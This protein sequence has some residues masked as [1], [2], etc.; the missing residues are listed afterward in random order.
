[1]K[2]IS[3]LW[4]IT[5]LI[6]FILGFSLFLAGIVLIGNY[7]S[8]KEE[9]LK[10]RSFVTA[11]TIAELPEVKEALEQDDGGLNEVIDRLRVIN[12][13]NYIVV[14][15]M[16]RIR[17]THPVHERIG[18]VSEGADEGP[19]FAEHS[20]TSKAKGEI[21]TVMRA[22]VPVMNDAHEQIGVVLAGY[23]VPSFTEVLE[24]LAF[25]IAITSGLSL[26][27]GGWG[28]WILARQ[29]KKQMFKLEPHEIARLLVERTETF[30][31]MH[32]GVIAIDTDENITIFNKKA[33]SMM[34]I[35]G[36]VTGRSIRDVIPDT[37]LP[38]ILE[39]DHGIYS[40]ELNVHNLNI[41][42]NRVPIKVNGETIGAV[43]IFQ[44]RTE[45][46]KMAEELT[47]VRAFVNALR[48]QNHEYNNKLHTIAGLIQLG[49]YEK[50]LQ[51]VF[52]TTEEQDELIQF[53]N[54][55]IKD[56][57]IAGLL[58]SKIRRGKELGIAVEIDRSSRFELFPPRI[59][60]HDLVLII[61]NLIENAFDSF[62]HG[63]C[64]KPRIFVSLEQVSGQSILIVE[65]NGS[66]IRE[67]DLP[68]I[69]DQG[70]STKGGNE[71]GI[72]LYMVRQLIHQ[73]NGSIQA[74]SEEGA[75]TSFTV[76]F[77]ME[78]M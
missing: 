25:E 34:R 13:A 78:E 27:F 49:N 51:F 65:D 35:E 12:N 70:F 66:G 44:D 53:L 21:G 60:H 20:Y 62:Q 72:G 29:I 45:V 61:G 30:N 52:Q 2:R 16:D 3:I 14:M 36:D 46:K 37:A 28:A 24:N 38:E 43:A 4:K 77:Q 9:E 18:T 76:T 64:S 58:L 10:A 1:M 63:E 48:V 11:Q 22:F 17:L 31:A 71:R 55:N 41:L 33:R 74:E 7:I 8:G 54:R 42:S 69:F 68:F 39:L 75:G 40:K 32:E 67:Q 73:A 19:A 15:N 6:F 26:L 56:E 50:A 57:S 47:G 23:K 5:G 59:D